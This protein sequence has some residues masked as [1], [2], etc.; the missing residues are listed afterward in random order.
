MNRF[1][2]WSVWSTSLM[3]TATGLVYLWM[4]YLLAP[5]EPWA[6]IHHPL[7][8]LVLK[9]HIVTA[10]LLVFAVGMIAT[11]HVWKHYRS[12]LSRGRRSGIGT[13]LVLAP[14][15][16]SGYLIQ[17]L[18]GEGWVRA[19]AVGHIATGLGYAAALVLHQ[20]AVRRRAARSATDSSNLPSL[21]APV[22]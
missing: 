14:M 7:Q 21:S 13:M 6:V 22:R 20:V 5:S 9:L 17:V 11:R 16:A 19:M 8:P 3:T 2:R 18:T 1:E 12:R 4:K 10:P 15:V